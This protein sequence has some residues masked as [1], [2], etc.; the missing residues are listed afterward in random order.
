MT[1]PISSHRTS[2][3]S[4]EMLPGRDTI[5]ERSCARDPIYP[6]VISQMFQKPEK[7]C[8]SCYVVEF[9]TIRSFVIIDTVVVIILIAMMMMTGVDGER[10][11]APTK[12]KS[13]AGRC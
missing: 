13:K 5:D 12:L 7:M 3:R 9:A 6:S 11:N 2:R 4:R 10:S 8:R 1:A